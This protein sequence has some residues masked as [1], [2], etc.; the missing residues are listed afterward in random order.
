[1]PQGKGKTMDTA[2][3]YTETGFR[4]LE[5]GEMW[6]GSVNSVHFQSTTTGATREQ[7]S[8]NSPIYNH[9]EIN[10]KECLVA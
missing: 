1:M 2:W 7:W 5:G 6:T 3:D 10:I 4:M 9:E 8:W